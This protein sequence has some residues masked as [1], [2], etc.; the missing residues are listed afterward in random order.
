MILEANSLLESFPAS[1]LE[2]SDE[3]LTAAGL[4]TVGVLFDALRTN[5]VVLAAPRV[6]DMER[7]EGIDTAFKLL[8]F[9]LRPGDGDFGVSFDTVLAVSSSPA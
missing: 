3:S 8:G 4:R 6:R 1:Y 7:E 5:R 9:F 2:T